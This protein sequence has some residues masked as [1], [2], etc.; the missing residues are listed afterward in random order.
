MRV[1]TGAVVLIAIAGNVPAQSAFEVA[2]VKPDA[3][4]T[5]V[6]RINITKGNLIIQNVSLRRLINMAYGI[7][8][9]R[10]YMLAGPDWLGSERFDISAKY[11]P[12]IRDEDVPPML[13]SLLSER[14]NL[15]LHRETRQISGYAL[16]TGKNRPKLRAA[17]SPR[18]FANF[19]ALSGHAEGTCVSSGRFYRPDWQI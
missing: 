18:T 13:Q 15:A 4:E 10:E 19:R 9:G 7:P 17:A 6:D 5:G 2:S 12:E 8:D 1:I 11:S 16:V 3:S 14:F